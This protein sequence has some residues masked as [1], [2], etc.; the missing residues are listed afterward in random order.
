MNTDRLANVIFHNPKKLTESDYRSICSD[1]ETDKFTL[2]EHVCTY[3][4]Y[5]SVLGKNVYLLE[6]GTTVLVSPELIESI[7]A[8]NIDKTKLQAFMLQSEKNFKYVL[9]TIY[10]WQQEK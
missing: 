8:L 9:G 10:K 6:D 5:D 3:K 1:I 4:K 2:S 7:N